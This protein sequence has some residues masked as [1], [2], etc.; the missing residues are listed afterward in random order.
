MLFILAQPTLSHNDHGIRNSS[1]LINR[2]HPDRAFVESENAR[3]EHSCIEFARDRVL[4]GLK[5]LLILFESAQRE[6]YIEELC[7]DTV[8]C[9]HH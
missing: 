5:P 8:P 7:I 1:R 2:Q 4:K 3:A 6:L 9:I